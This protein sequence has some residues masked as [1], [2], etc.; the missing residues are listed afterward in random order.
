[1]GRNLYFFNIIK[2][3]QITTIWGIYYTYVFLWFVICL[4]TRSPL[5]AIY[6]FS[7]MKLLSNLE[8]NPNWQ[9][10]WLPGQ[11]CRCHYTIRYCSFSGFITVIISD[12]ITR[13]RNN[14]P[15][16]TPYDL[17]FYLKH[18]IC[19]SKSCSICAL[20]N[21]RCAINNNLNKHRG[22]EYN[23]LR[24]ITPINKTFDLQW[25]TTLYLKQTCLI[26]NYIHLIY[27]TT[28]IYYFRIY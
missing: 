15:R 20:I 26:K 1:M 5:C 28:A 22:H 27:V 13:K 6:N 4:Q 12:D 14:M 7:K 3:I 16:M 23:L 18:L 21:E 8:M 2:K 25:K 17:D 10:L 11:R 9:I 24:L 19:N